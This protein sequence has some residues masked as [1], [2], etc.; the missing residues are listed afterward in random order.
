MKLKGLLKSS[1]SV[2][3][4]S[5]NSLKCFH[6]N[7]YSCPYFYLKFHPR[8][9]YLSLFQKSNPLAVHYEYSNKSLIFNNTLSSFINK[10]KALRM[11]QTIGS[12]DPKDV[13]TLRKRSK[14]FVNK[15]LYEFFFKQLPEDKVLTILKKSSEIRKKEIN[16]DNLSPHDIRQAFE[17]VAPSDISEEYHGIILFKFLAFPSK[18]NYNVYLENMRR[19][20]QLTFRHPKKSYAKE[21]KTFNDSTYKL[22]NSMIRSSFNIDS[23]MYIPANEKKVIIDNIM[24]NPEFQ[25][26][27]KI[28]RT[29]TRSK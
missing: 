25:Q 9:L 23:R 6:Q 16:K 1:N 17:F 7:S 27:F 14:H 11:A 24:Q 22:V 12:I 19:A 15:F 21:V 26:N 4:S 28:N 20:F 8:Q 29:V 13:A 5:L 18:E 2:L 3:Y 10:D